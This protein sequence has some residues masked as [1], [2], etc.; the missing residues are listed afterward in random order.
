MFCQ[1]CGHQLGDEDKFCVECGTPVR[2]E[3][4]A[5]VTEPFA[6]ANEP[7]KPTQ[8]AADPGRVE[9]VQYGS[10]ESDFGWNKASSAQSAQFSENEPHYKKNTGLFVGIV[11]GIGVLI[12]IILFVC[13]TVSGSQARKHI[14]NNAPIFNESEDE[15]EDNG[16]DFDINESDDFADGYDFDMDND[17]G[18]Y[19]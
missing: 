19:F 4:N 1:N 6:A 14:T 8:E 15:D 16:F 3:E 7:G 18:D 11:A 10:A 5:A 9:P 13:V 2:T 17:F 12:M